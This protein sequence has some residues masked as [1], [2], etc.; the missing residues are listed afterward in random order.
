MPITAIDAAAPA[1]NDFASQ[2][3]ATQRV[4]RAKINELITQVNLDVLAI[5]DH[6][7]RIDVLEGA[8]A[9]TVGEIK[10]KLQILTGS[11]SFVVPSNINGEVIYA[12][13]IAG[14]Q[15]G[16]GGSGTPDVKGADGTDS[17]LTA[18]E[19][20]MPVV[21]AA[22]LAYA[23]GAGSAGTVGAIGSVGAFALMG[24][25]TSLGKYVATPKQ[26]G[27]ITNGA[28]NSEEE[29]TLASSLG[30]G[31]GSCTVT[32]GAGFPS[33]GG[34]NY[35]YAELNN[36]T[37]REL[38]KV[39]NRAA[40]T[41][42]ITRAQFG[43]T[44]QAWPAGTPIF[45]IPGPIYRRAPLLQ[46]DIPPLNRLTSYGKGGAG[47]AGTAVPAT[48]GATGANGNDGCIILRWYERQ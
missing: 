45:A 34:S 32:A 4:A 12:T 18:V 16:Q 21:A 8:A 39:T 47:G 46:K 40:N 43:T 22:S 6:E 5:A 20:I 13:L 10:E 19:V 1:D 36:G 26:A 23:C 25:D 9:P 33:P 41:F 24:G 29:T 7:S 48:P 14:G 35:F 44:D 3:A 30:I 17:G 38:I 11:G 37:V 28:I 15:G 2:S 31:S 27:T 42:T